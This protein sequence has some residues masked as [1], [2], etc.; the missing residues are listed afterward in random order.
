MEVDDK[1]VVYNVSS[2]GPAARAELKGNDVILA[3]NG[4]RLKS[5]IEFYR[6]LWALGP[7]GVDVTLT[8]YR[9]GDTFDVTITSID[10]SKLQK[11]P[12]LH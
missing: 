7:A 11:R 8:L 12:R 4:E 10:R 9:D 5:Q 3:I 2:R 6:K 1:I